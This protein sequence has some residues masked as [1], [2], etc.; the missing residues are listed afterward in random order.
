MGKPQVPRTQWHPDYVVPEAGDSSL[1]VTTVQGRRE[2]EFYKN[3]SRASVKSE[4]Q[5]VEARA[6]QALCEAVIG[7]SKGE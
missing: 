6:C 4:K 5:C 1:V 7:Q 3:L 2:A